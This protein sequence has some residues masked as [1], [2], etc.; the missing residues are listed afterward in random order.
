MISHHT[1]IDFQVYIYSAALKL[2]LTYTVYMLH[3]HCIEGIQ[4][5]KAAIFNFTP[6]HFMASN[7]YYKLNFGELEQ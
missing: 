3:W 4:N 2:T 7:T 6:V 1:N 5:F